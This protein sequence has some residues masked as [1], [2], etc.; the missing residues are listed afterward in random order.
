V[1][2]APLL[3]RGEPALNADPDAQ[4]TLLDLQATDSALDRIAHR[5]TTLPV[6]ATLASLAEQHHR[7][8]QALAATD[9][10]IARGEAAVAAAEDAVAGVR[11]HRRRD[12]ERLD[13]G[14]VS[15][16]RELEAL[17]HAIGTL[18]VRQETLE[19]V[20]L[21][22]MEELEQL[23]ATREQ[24]QAERTGVEERAAAATAERDAALA[25]LDA[26]ADAGRERRALLA[27]EV[28]ADLRALYDTVRTKS[29]GVGAAA[30]RGARCEG[31]RIELNQAELARVRALPPDAVARCEE[32]RRILV[33]V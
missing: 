30:L 17:Q 12:Q 26:E 29:G 28:P 8:V 31:C 15:S 2:G 33:R 19:D 22:A 13:A 4:L 27:A 20:E 3:R 5:R 1:V 6:L 9:V 18:A 25:E 23:Q 7:L 21:A 11:A 10:E 32:C 16:P 14:R 24:L